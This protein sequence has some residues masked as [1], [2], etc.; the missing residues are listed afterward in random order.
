MPYE[1]CDDYSAIWREA[2]VKARKE[3]RCEE[4]REPIPPGMEY[5]KATSLYDGRWDTLRRCAA[6]LILAEWI[7]TVT[8]YCP[9]WGGLDVSVGYAND[10][11]ETYDE[12]LDE[13][14]KP[15]PDPL[16]HRR[17]WDAIAGEP[18]P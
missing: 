6:C 5:G 13:Y 14:V 18:E 3:H 1:E 2:K 17:R 12:E 10:E 11:H 4:C 9:L 15:F 8:G 16:T 7:A